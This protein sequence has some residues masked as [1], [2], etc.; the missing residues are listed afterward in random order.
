SDA[1]VGSVTLPFTEEEEFCA[2][3]RM[4]LMK[5]MAPQNTARTLLREDVRRFSAA[6]A[7]IGMPRYL[8]IGLL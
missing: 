7:G 6:M 8:G 5:R 2:L 4:A 3:A 1:P